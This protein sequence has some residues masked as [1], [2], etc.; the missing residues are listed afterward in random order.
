MQ[1]YFLSYCRHFPTSLSRA[2]ELKME[3]IVSK[4]LRVSIPPPISID[5]TPLFI[6]KRLQKT[7]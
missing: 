5:E 6:T 3:K 4:T 1:Y 7:F 2:R